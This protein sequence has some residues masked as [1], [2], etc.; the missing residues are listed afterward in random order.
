M[1]KEILSIFVYSIPVILIATFVLS[2]VLF[3]KRN[4][5]IAKYNVGYISSF[6]LCF[7]YDLPDYNWCCGIAGK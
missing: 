1:R 6:F 4:K 2:I 7:L 5:I 3:V